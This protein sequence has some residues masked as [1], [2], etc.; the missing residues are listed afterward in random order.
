MLLELSNPDPGLLWGILSRGIGLVYLVSFASL[1]RQVLPSAGR[2]GITPVSQALRAIERADVQRFWSEL[3]PACAP[4]RHD[5]RGAKALSERL[6][7]EYGRDQLVRFELLVGRYGA[8]LF[9]KLEPLFLD[10]GPKALFGRGAATLNLRSSFHV[11][12]LAQHVIGEG[13]AVYDAAMRAPG[14]AL[15]EASRMSM[16]SGLHFQ[17]LL[18]HEALA[19][20]ARKQRL[21]EAYERREGRPEPSQGERERLEHIDATLKRFFGSMDVAAFLRTQFATGEDHGDVAESWPRFALRPDGEVVRVE[22]G[23]PADADTATS[24]T[25]RVPR[26][27]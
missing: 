7:D 19:Y 26:T 12:L 4:C 22:P 25:P 6:R 16:Q 2:D 24:P 18:R 5:F 20:Q 15:E 8:L 14:R 10:G 3:V 21:L 17:A 1:S 11:R 27:T 9:G 23:G 13:R